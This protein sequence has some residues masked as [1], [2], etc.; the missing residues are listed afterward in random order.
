MEM[1]GKGCDEAMEKLKVDEK[2]RE[3]LKAAVEEALGQVVVV[4]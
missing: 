4:N 1:L 3:S 2:D